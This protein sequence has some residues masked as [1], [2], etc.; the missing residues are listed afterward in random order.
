M[1]T[2]YSYL[3]FSTPE[4][5]KG[6]SFR[7]QSV[8]ASR[9][10]DANGLDLDTK[11]RFDD[12]GISAFK[13]RNA[14]VGAL[15]RFL[16]LVEAGKIE[17][18]SYLLV[19]SL[20]RISRDSVRRAMR[21]LEEIV[22]SGV[23]LVTL[24]DGK[25]WDRSSLDDFMSWM[26][27]SL[28]LFR[29]HNE[30][31]EKARRLRDSWVGRRQLA[32]KGTLRLTTHGPAWLEPTETGWR[33]LPE[34]A[35]VVR[36]ICKEFV[37]GRGVEGI[38]RDLNADA[39]P[40]F[41]RPHLTN[42]ATASM[43]RGTYLQRMLSNAALVGHLDMYTAREGKRVLLSRAERYYP[44]VI[45][46]EQWADVQA[47]LNSRAPQRGK[48][49]G[50]PLQ[51]VFAGLLRCACGGSVTRIKVNAPN[52]NVYNYLVCDA[53]RRKVGCPA[54]N[55]ARIAYATALPVVVHHLPDVLSLAP[56]DRDLGAALKQAELNLL[57]M[58]G[59]LAE[60]TT[61]R[62]ADALA[63]Q[64][65]IAEQKRDALRDQARGSQGLTAG[66]H[67]QALLAEIQKKQ[68]D[69]TAVNQGLRQLVS[70]ISV[71]HESY[72]LV[73]HW[74]HAPDAPSRVPYSTA[75]YGFT[76]REL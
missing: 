30:S 71:D 5:L 27:A 34:R 62:A 75:A 46:G 35:K 15:R 76:A 13:G 29:G 32:Q 57:A 8:M 28:T 39:V 58:E 43:W 21:V 33:L 4:Q 60:A 23:L 66:K 36:R 10:A 31:S 2:A 61:A 12:L 20:D 73:L 52:G 50:Q 65:E 7:R 53:S 24:T 17:Q 59:Q 6:D 25:V 68:L 41:D 63:R 42:R 45:T 40:T 70:R 69:P 64:V 16:D 56:A 49:V 55:T 54:G 1:P 22:E 9:F 14:E 26:M 51:N 19:E 3:R 48:H 67:A 38:A 37:A 72:E 11:L 18:G 74:H 47:R 44:A